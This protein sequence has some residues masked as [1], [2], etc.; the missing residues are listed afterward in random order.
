VRDAG[1]PQRAGR[2][3]AVA[4]LAVARDR[5]HEEAERGAGDPVREVP[6]PAHALARPEEARPEH[7]VRPAA[8]D[9]LE[10]AREVGRVV[11]AVAVDVDGRGVALVAGCFEPG[12]KRGSET[13]A[14]RMGDDA[15]AELA[16]DAGRCIRGAVVDEQHIDRKPTSFRRKSTEDAAHSSL[17]ISRN[18]D[19]QAPPGRRCGT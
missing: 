3:G 12:P 14:V 19:R 4:G 18:D 7:V 8:R 2:E 5:L 11:L 6:V 10:H 13:A 16:P 15:R 1:V 17:L 9:R